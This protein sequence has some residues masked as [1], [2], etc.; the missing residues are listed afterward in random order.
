MVVRHDD[1][2]HR[3]GSSLV[4]NVPDCVSQRL[5]FEQLGDDVRL[6]IVRADF[7]NEGGKNLV[8][9]KTNAGL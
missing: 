9:A 4:L 7:M 5:P 6:T 1:S 8:R 3:I 2:D